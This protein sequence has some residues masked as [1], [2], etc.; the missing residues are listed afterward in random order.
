VLEIGAGFGTVMALILWFGMPVFSRLFTSDSGVLESIALL[1]PFVALTQPINALA[2]VFDGL[3]YGASDFGYV[4]YTMVR[5]L[6]IK[7]FP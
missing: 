2:F 3:H 5:C 6:H 4:A 7:M 1:I